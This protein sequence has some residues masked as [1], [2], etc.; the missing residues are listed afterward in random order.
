[1]RSL[2]VSGIAGILLSSLILV[3]SAGCGEGPTG[4]ETPSPAE[5]VKLAGHLQAG[6]VTERLPERLE[7]VVVDAEGDSLPGVAL[8]WTPCGR[9]GTVVDADPATNSRGRARATWVLGT[10]TG[11]RSVTVRAG[12]RQAV[13]NATALPGPPHALE[14]VTGDAQ[15]GPPGDRLPVRINVR[16]LDEHG[17][18]VGGAVVAWLV[19]AGGGHVTDAA[20]VAGPD[21]IAGAGWVLGGPGAQ[22]LDV[23]A[24]GVVLSF[25][26]TADATAIADA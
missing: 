15:V 3:A 21:G 4:A 8:S 25:T 14:A 16:V 5:V 1:M 23:R 22:R 12:D 17:N 13:F 26:A 6:P 10:T 7:V 18:A 19:T 11:L 9:G 20:G 2:H 24:G